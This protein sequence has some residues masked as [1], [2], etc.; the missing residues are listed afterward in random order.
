MEHAAAFPFKLLVFP[1]F[2]SDIYAPCHGAVQ[3][4]LH[5]GGPHASPGLVFCIAL[6][7]HSL[8]LSLAFCLVW[9]S[10]S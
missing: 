7:L 10:P 6:N 3:L 9:F 2:L 5:S 4:W 1:H 8:H